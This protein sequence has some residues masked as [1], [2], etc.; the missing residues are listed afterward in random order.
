MEKDWT[1]IYTVNKAYQADL[2][3]ELLKE[4]DIAG[5]VI[6]KRDSSFISSGEYEIYV[7]DKDAEKARTLLQKS[8]I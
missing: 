4:E 3:L 6:N 1:L 7:S 8:K 5:V 2:C